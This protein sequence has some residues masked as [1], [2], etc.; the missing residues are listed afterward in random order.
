MP[1]WSLKR[2]IRNLKS[3]YWKKKYWC[4]V[5]D[6]LEALSV[7]VQEEFDGLTDGDSDKKWFVRA[8][9]R[10]FALL[11]NTIVDTVG[12]IKRKLKNCRW[13]GVK[14]I[15]RTKTTVRRLNVDFNRTV[16][17]PHCRRIYPFKIR[18]TLLEHKTVNIKRMV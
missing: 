4:S 2:F 8:L 18:L 1:H 16:S 11:L 14:N 9:T 6:F 5:F 17:G 15:A 12:K 10:I 7:K 13:N 3:T